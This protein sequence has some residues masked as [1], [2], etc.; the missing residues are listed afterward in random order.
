M[1]EPEQQ[2]PR[3]KPA[4]DQAWKESIFATDKFTK[5][6]RRTNTVRD[7]YN[8][9]FNDGAWWGVKHGAFEARRLDAARPEPPEPDGDL[10]TAARKEFGCDAG[11]HTRYFK[12]TCERIASFAATVAARA[13]APADVCG[14][15]CA[16][17]DTLLS[18]DTAVIYDDSFAVCKKCNTETAEAWEVEKAALRAEGHKIPC[19]FFE[20]NPQ[21]TPAPTSPERRDALDVLKR[22]RQW[23]H[24]DT[25]ADGNYWKSQI[26]TAI[27]KLEG[28]HE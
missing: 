3:M 15:R 25:A 11:L 2:E 6:L 21:F 23:D 16:E 17:C 28:K 7:I 14:R 8:E 10:V 26:D 1:N 22:L 5:D 24:L 20:R 18:A 4:R 12:E 9:G 19:D 13:D 27:D